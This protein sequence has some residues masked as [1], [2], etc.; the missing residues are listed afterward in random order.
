MKTEIYNAFGVIHQTLGL[1]NGIGVKGSAEQLRAKL[2]AGTEWQNK[3][4]R[5]EGIQNSAQGPQIFALG[6]KI[7]AVYLH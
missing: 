1:D 6:Q 5:F 3:T 2:F 4:L 7:E